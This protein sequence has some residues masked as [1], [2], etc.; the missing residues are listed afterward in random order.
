MANLIRDL[1][2]APSPREQGKTLLDETMVVMITEF[3][4]VQAR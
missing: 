4:R 1:S 2:A 3:G